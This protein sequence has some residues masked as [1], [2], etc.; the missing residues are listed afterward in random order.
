MATVEQGGLD[1]AAVGIGKN[2]LNKQNHRQAWPY[3]NYRSYYSFRSAAGAG[4]GAGETSATVAGGEDALDGRLALLD[5]S[6]FDGKVLLDIGT[7]AGKVAID[8]VSHLGCTRAVG[9]DIDPLL[10][11]DA[12]AHAADAAEEGVRSRLTFF[13]DSVMQLGWFDAR[14][15][16][17]LAGV[18]VVTLFSITKW[19]HLHHGDAG[20]LRLFADL[21]AFLPPGGVLIVEPQEFAN[22]RRAVKRN[23]DLRETFKAIELWPPFD[24]ELEAAGF[25]LETRIEREE[26]G[27]SRPLLVWRKPA[28]T[29][30][31]AEGA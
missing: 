26:G 31:A 29:T 8:A 24:R 22:Y 30:G 2:Q 14:R 25:V 4:T 13:A 20:L 19:L 28:A 16:P 3:G 1:A 18:D 10:I 27:F 7:N 23:P 5:R 17:R 6:L 12:C 9:V 21:H 15:E 11:Q